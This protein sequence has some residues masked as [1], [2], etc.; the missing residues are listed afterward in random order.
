MISRKNLP[1][2]QDAGRVLWRGP[3]FIYLLPHHCLR[4]YISNYTLTFPTSEIISDTYTVMPHGSATL[5]VEVAEK[6]MTINLFGPASKA[7]TVGIAACE[8][9]LIVE[10]QPAGLFALTGMNQSEFTDKNVL[11]RDVN[12]QLD[13]EISNLVE[14]SQSISELIDEYDQLLYERLYTTYHPNLRQVLG[15]I[16]D[17]KGNVAVQEL[18][19]EIHYSERQLG[20]IFKEQVG[21]STKAFSNVVRIN[22]SLRLLGDSRKDLN[23]V[24]DLSGFHD[25]PHFNREFKA[26][27]GVTPRQYRQQMSDFY[28]EIAKF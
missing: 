13:Q 8:F 22:H 14:R 6:E 3:E 5:V 20:R 12:P 27:C 25:L 9:L 19:A 11:L 2:Y 10:F 4:P 1:D 17:A 18:A 26:L 7:M 16:V 21:V 24:A 23:F 28:N 15:K